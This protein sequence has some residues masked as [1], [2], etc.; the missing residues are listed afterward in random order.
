[1][2]YLIGLILLIICFSETVSAQIIQREDLDF[3]SGRW[4]LKARLIYPESTEPIPFL[5]Y[6]GGDEGY[7]SYNKDYFSFLQQNFE[8]VL[9]AEGY[10]LFYINTQG[11]DGSE[12][13]WQRADYLLRAE[14]IETGLRI[15]RQRDI[16][17]TSRI[18]LFGHGEG[19]YLAQ[20]VG[21]KKQNNI[22]AILNLAAPTFDY[23]TKVLNAYHGE[24]VCTGKDS[25][26]A[27]SKAERQ[28]KSSLGWVNTFP[29]IKKWR[30]GK[31][32]KD[33]NPAEY[34]GNLTI[35]SLFVFAEN[36]EEIYSDW[37]MEALEELFSGDIPDYFYFEEISGANHSFR[38]GDKCFIG[39]I[40][41]LPFS[42]QFKAVV[43][44]W[45]KT[46]L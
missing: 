31:V 25:T 28:T 16:V 46:H 23:R 19:A 8:D 43:R 18:A 1:M 5:V 2:K 45:V 32:N 3:Q 39:D 9:L 29:V 24:Y 30:H 12:G 38:D 13:R 40:T 41:T 36:D 26:A 42:N 27:Y 10:G 15:L 35:P 33:F 44:D 14:D 4:N 37:A 7:E 11:I 22:A 21:S 6:V 20:I 34:I 17:D